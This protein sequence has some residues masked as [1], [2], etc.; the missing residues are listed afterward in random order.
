[1]TIII[2][3]VLQELKKTLIEN[4]LDNMVLSLKKSTWKVLGELRRP[5]SIIIVIPE[6]VSAPIFQMPLFWAILLTIVVSVAC[7]CPRQA[8][9]RYFQD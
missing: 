7:V 1:M 4:G 8:G 2:Q 5:M 9:K 6:H 3:E